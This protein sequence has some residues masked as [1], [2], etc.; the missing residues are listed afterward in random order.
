MERYHQ[1]LAKILDTQFL[2]EKNLIEAEIVDLQEQLEGIKLNISELGFVGNVSKEFLDRHSELKGDI[3]ALQ[4]QNQAF[5]T[6][7]A[8][9]ASKQKAEEVLKKVYQIFL[10]K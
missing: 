9:Q 8:L 4:T 5:L 1:K 2:N 7:K 10:E 6:L 3:N